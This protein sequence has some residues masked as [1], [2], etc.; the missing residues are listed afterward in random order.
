MA[1]AD[2]CYKARCA[3]VAA[4]L[5]HRKYT[6]V[7]SRIFRL[8][9]PRERGGPWSKEDDARL[10]ELHSLHGTKWKRVGEELGRLPLSCRDRWR[11]ID[12]PP[13]TRKGKW[14][15]EEADAL[16]AAVAQFSTAEGLVRRALL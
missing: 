6:A 2:S 7:W 13:G 3:Q 11:Q 14:S 16:T 12:T 4:I 15:E 5:P 10:R 8:T 1:S 9:H